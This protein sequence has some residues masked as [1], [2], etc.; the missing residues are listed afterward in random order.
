MDAQVDAINGS[1]IT[2]VSGN[3]TQLDCYSVSN[4]AIAFSFELARCI[5]Q[6]LMVG[7]ELSAALQPRQGFLAYPYRSGAAVLEPL[8]NRQRT[9]ARA[10]CLKNTAIAVWRMATAVMFGFAVPG[11]DAKHL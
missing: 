6:A 8:Q 10:P 2:N 5:H 3:A 11:R 7:A 9:Q 4:I 1:D